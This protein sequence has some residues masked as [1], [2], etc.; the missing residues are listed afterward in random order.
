MPWEGTEATSQWIAAW[1]L[2]CMGA[3]IMLRPLST[4]AAVAAAVVFL[5]SRAAALEHSYQSWAS[6]TQQLAV[7][8]K[9]ELWLDE[10][11]RRRADSSLF[12]VRPALGYRLLE[13][14]T[15]HAG[16]AWVPVVEDGTDSVFHEHRIWQQLLWSAA[17]TDT[18]AVMVRP[19]LEQRFSD[20]G[21]DVG[22]RARCFARVN[23]GAKEQ[24]VLLA[25]WD[26]LFVALNTT[27]WGPEPGFDQNRFFV[28]PGFQTDLG[29]RFE[30]GYLNVYLRGTPNQMAHVLA[31]N[32]FFLR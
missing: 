26:E 9:L 16:Y 29:V 21:S 3:A 14:L 22:H 10:H 23:I 31:V 30:V 1:L 19:R 4:S 15:L 24:P 32:A 18:V 7:T 6:G 17:L 5:S 13:G 27:D 12:I 2:W 28:G 11:A 8:P 20:Q 25:L